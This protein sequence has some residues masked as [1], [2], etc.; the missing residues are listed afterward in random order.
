MSHIIIPLTTSNET[1]NF[2]ANSNFFCG[3]RILS[4]PATHLICRGRSSADTAERHC[5]HEAGGRGPERIHILASLKKV[6]LELGEGRR[7]WHKAETKREG[8]GAGRGTLTT[9]LGCLDQDALTSRSLPAWWGKKMVK[10]DFI[11]CKH[12]LSP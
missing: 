6:T 9:G 1:G 10:V 4:T 2:Q 8:P 3:F 5:V 12:L 7:G 11:R